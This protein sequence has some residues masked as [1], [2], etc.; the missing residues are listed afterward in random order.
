MIHHISITTNEVKTKIKTGDIKFGGNK[1]LKI[2]GTLNCKSG[3]RIKRENRVFF[4]S[5]EEAIESNFRPCG[6]CMKEAYKK[7]KNE[8][9]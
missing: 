1:N 6:N 3:L 2:Y 5:I 9:V 4:S 8:I 7:W